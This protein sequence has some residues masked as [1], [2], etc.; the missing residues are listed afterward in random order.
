MVT[1]GRPPEP[2]YPI[3]PSPKCLRR[4]GLAC[5]LRYWLDWVGVA[6]TSLPRDPARAPA[7]RVVRIPTQPEPAY[8]RNYP[9]QVACCRAPIHSVGNWLSERMSL[10]IWAR[11]NAKKNP[12]KKNTRI[13]REYVISRNHSPITQIDIQPV[14]PTP[15]TNWVDLPGGSPREVHAGA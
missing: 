15:L 8:P 3:A 5:A 6:N 7:G 10:S 13:E 1:L 9:R 12:G 4:A 14:R 2:V 11:E